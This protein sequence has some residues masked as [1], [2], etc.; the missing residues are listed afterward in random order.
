[1]DVLH[2]T[3]FFPKLWKA[4]KYPSEM[5]EDTT[6][7]QENPLTVIEEDN[8]ALTWGLS[9]N[10]S[11]GVVEI[12][13][14][15]DGVLRSLMYLPDGNFSGQDS[16]Q[17]YVSDGIAE[18]YFTYVFYIPNINDVPLIYNEDLNLSIKEGDEY[19]FDIRFNDGD[20]IGNHINGIFQ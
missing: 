5:I 1:M 2:G 8:Q 3:I 13:A 12:N 10:A 6:W 9:L 17:L 7:F 20:G 15:E 16:F 18:D 11:N 4:R 14:T 19:H